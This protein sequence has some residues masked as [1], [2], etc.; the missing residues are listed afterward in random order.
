MIE[1]T[2]LFTGDLPEF[3]ARRRLNA[4]GI[5]PRQ[6]FIEKV[7][8]FPENIEAKVTDDLPPAAAG[9]AGLPGPA[10][11]RVRSRSA[12]TP[13]AGAASPCCCTTAWS[14]CPTSR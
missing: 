9:R 6:T 14:S 12:A 11:A 3:S 1:V 7:K 4:S 5:D 8:A 13:T 10:R 2:S